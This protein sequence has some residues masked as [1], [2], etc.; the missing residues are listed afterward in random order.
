[1]QHVCLH[2][3]YVSPPKKTL[4]YPLNSLIYGKSAC[5]DTFVGVILALLK[6][7]RLKY[8]PE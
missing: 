1:M 2:D 3:L 8:Y 4:Y 7:G 5:N 6:D